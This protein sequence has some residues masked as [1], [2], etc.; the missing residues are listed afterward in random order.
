MSIWEFILRLF[1][2]G[3]WPA[4]V[5]FM[6][7][8][9]RSDISRL[10]LAIKQLKLPGGTEVTIGELVEEVEESAAKAQSASE[11]TIDEPIKSEIRKLLDKAQADRISQSIVSFDLEYYKTLALQDPNLALAGLRMGMERVLSDMADR[12]GISQKPHQVTTARVAKV[13]ASR[14]ELPNELRT[15]LRELQA[16][17]NQAV[18]GMQ[19]TS[20]EAIRTIN[21]AEP[22]RTYYLSWLA[23]QI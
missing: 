23:K 7:L 14:N 20:A 4:V 16:I 22:L 12:L 18:H 3:I 10:V 13:L 1:D 6:L 11:S 2:S 19:I 8:F 17:S 21:A 15:L 9:Y 5:L